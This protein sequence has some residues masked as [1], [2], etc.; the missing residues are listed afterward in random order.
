MDQP[1][2]FSLP[3]AE[4]SDP[5]HSGGVLSDYRVLALKY[6]P[7]DFS[8]VVGQEQVSSVLMG[9]LAQNRVANAYLFAGP[10]GCG[11]TTTARI[12][13]KALNCERG[14]TSSPCGEC[15]PCKAIVSG[16]SL[17]VIEIDAAS[18]GGVEDIRS[19][20]SEA[21]LASMGG[22]YKVYILDEAHQI[23]PAGANALLKTLEEP[24][25]NTVF[26]LAT[27]EGQKIIPTIHSRCQRFHFRLLSPAEI[28]GRLEHILAQEGVESESEALHAIARRAEGSMRDGLTLLDQILASM[29]G[30]VTLSQVTE[31]LGLTPN[32]R[33][34]GLSDAFVARDGAAALIEIDRVLASG[35][36]VRDFALGLAGYFRNLLFLRLDPALLDTEMS[37]SDREGC[38][39]YA[40]AFAVE[41]LLYLTRLCGERADQIRYS[42]QPRIHLETLV[43]EIARLESRILLSEI[44]GRLGG[45]RPGAPSAGGGGRGAAVPAPGAAGAEKRGA[46]PPASA[47]RE[48]EGRA[49]SRE[50]KRAAP[51]PEILREKPSAGPADAAPPAAPGGNLDMQAGWGV[52]VNGVSNGKKSLGSFL[53]HARPG[54][55]GA[56]HFTLHVESPFHLAMIDTP[57]HIRMM[58]ETFAQIFGERRQIRLELVPTQPGQEQPTRRVSVERAEDARRKQDLQDHAGDALIED[59]LQRFDGE[60]LED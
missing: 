17:A 52:F 23:S 24:P 44:L 29:D 59:L 11:K 14:P 27:T 9:A 15:G 46:A 47:R 13:A 42:S 20:R 8:E 37:A 21:A 25:P 51:S 50:T 4:G 41:D 35:V 22:R 30:P 56:N 12:L 6:R 55:L 3:G 31:I 5:K 2:P 40:E 57:E 48:A 38:A 49:P 54:G 1:G 36:S 32:D 58:G 28:A 16:N 26:I 18:T 33:F 34:F 39:E 7:R 19:I 60:I 43:V 45:G 10:R 53:A